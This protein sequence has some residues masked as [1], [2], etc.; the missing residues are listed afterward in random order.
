MITIER[1]SV[2]GN[3]KVKENFLGQ[4]WIY[5][6]Q[7][8]KNKTESYLVYKK[9]SEIYDLHNRLVKDYPR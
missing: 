1:L 2:S 3:A 6:L 7:V 5:A 4:T 8:A 9:W